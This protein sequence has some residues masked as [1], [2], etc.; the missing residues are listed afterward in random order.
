[1][2]VQDYCYIKPKNRDQD[3]NL[4]KY[5]NNKYVTLKRE[6][7]KIFTLKATPSPTLSLK[8]VTISNVSP[9]MFICR[10]EDGNRCLQAKCF[11]LTEESGTGLGAERFEVLENPEAPRF[12]TVAYFQF[13]LHSSAIISVKS[14]VHRILYESTDFCL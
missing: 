14:Q 6:G 1:M 7:K 13:H 11:D 8:T 10:S 3:Q 12:S 9:V 5:Q 4:N 2:F